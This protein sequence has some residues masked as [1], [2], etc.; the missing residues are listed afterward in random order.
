[1]HTVL[2]NKLKRNDYYSYSILSCSSILGKAFAPD[3]ETREANQYVPI[4]LEVP[5]ESSSQGIQL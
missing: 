5:W 4:F 2:E 3:V 1:M